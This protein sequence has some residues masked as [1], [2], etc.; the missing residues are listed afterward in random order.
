MFSILVNKKV[1]RILFVMTIMVLGVE[2]G[3]C[4]AESGALEDP[5]IDSALTLD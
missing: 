3:T 4:S 2:G 1:F 5:I